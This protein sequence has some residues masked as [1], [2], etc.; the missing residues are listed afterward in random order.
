MWDGGK[1]QIYRQCAVSKRV[2][3]IMVCVATCRIAQKD[4]DFLTGVSIYGTGQR[5]VR[6]QLIKA[7]CEII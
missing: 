1:S 7:G 6:A 3:D 5:T 2:A 4:V